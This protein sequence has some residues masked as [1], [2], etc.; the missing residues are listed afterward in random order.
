M[1]SESSEA[2]LAAAWST[3]S[4]SRASAETSRTFG[5]CHKGIHPDRFSA[6]FDHADVSRADVYKCGELLLGQAT[7]LTRSFIRCPTAFVSIGV[8]PSIDHSIAL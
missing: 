8:P 1:A 2:A 6:P 7:P 4:I 3:T 5:N